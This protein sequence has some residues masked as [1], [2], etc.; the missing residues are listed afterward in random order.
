MLAHIPSRLAFVAITCALAMPALA[1]HGGGGHAMGHGPGMGG[2]HSMPAHFDHQYGH[3]HYYPARGTWVSGLP[4][5]SL[6][7]AYGRAQWYFH[8][9]VWY[10]PYGSAFVVGLPPLGIVVPL[11]PLAYTTLWLDGSTY[12]YA[13]GTYYRAAPGG[14]AVVAPPPDAG[15]AQVMPDQSA[16]QPV[17]VP[18]VDPV[19]YPRAGQGQEQTDA[20]RQACQQWAMAQPGAAADAGVQQRGLAACMDARGYTVR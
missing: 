9:G 5:G 18:L 1:Q 3:D 11:L 15:A 6:S 17:A 19:I 16:P 12:Y 8:G 7:V 4:A 14:Y 2:M 10:R 13:N 20:D